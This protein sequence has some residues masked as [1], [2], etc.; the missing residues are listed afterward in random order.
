MSVLC[1]S[2]TTASHWKN[3]KL[4]S[5]LIV[6]KPELPNRFERAALEFYRA[7]KATR[8]TSRPPHGSYV[9]LSRPTSGPDGK[10]LPYAFQR[11]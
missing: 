1:G 4:F 8:V 9:Q 6:E 2:K 10:C 3:P 5:K 7:A 11:L